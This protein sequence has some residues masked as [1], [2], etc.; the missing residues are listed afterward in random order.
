MNQVADHAK[1]WL[2]LA[3]AGLGVT[4]APHEW[5]GGIFLALAAAAL[6]MRL[7]PEQDKRELWLVMLGAFLSAH[8]AALAYIWALERGYVPPFP[9][10]AV[11]AA[12]GFFS[13][14]IVRVLLRVGGLVDERVD[15]IA[16]AA[17]D[18]VLPDKPARRTPDDDTPPPRPDA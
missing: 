18:R 14:I 2:T 1:D 12:A 5:I 6:A 13:R 4:F 10:Q 15:D 11:M 17:V 3:L 9:K 16:D 7:D 8:F